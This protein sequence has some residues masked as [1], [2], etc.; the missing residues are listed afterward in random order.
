LAVVAA[1]MRQ[2]EDGMTKT[3]I[4]KDLIHNIIG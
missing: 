4:A 2:E 3:E 1:V